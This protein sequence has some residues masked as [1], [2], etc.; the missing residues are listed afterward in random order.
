[1]KNCVAAAL[2]PRQQSA[3]PSHYRPKPNITK[4][5]LYHAVSN[6]K[7][8]TRPKNLPKATAEPSPPTLVGAFWHCGCLASAPKA[9]AHM[10]FALFF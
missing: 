2:T 7:G 6:N 8:M 4:L 9:P 5:V 3:P 1:M 10:I